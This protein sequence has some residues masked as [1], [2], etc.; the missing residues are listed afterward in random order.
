MQEELRPL[1]QRIMALVREVLGPGPSET[2]VRFCGISIISQSVFPS[3]INR[4][5]SR[6]NDRRE[7]AWRVDDIEA[8]A[9]HVV[10]FSLAGM[11]AAT[12]KGGATGKD[13]SPYSG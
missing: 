2:E 3:F 7:D 10:L 6:V 1:R 12:R 13:C 8:Y 4:I 11:A 5:E 9:D